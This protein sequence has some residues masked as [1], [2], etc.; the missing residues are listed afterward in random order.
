MR[1]PQRQI[2]PWLRKLLRTVVRS[3][4]SKSQSSKI[5]TG[6]LPPSSRLSFLNMGAAVRAI[7]CPVRVPPVKEMAWMSGCAV[8]AAP[9]RGP[10][11]CTMLSTP[12]GMPASSHSRLIRYAV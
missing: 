7:S 8:I 11:P 5:S 6:F 9:T 10:V 1:E 4:A 2:C 3:M 12:G